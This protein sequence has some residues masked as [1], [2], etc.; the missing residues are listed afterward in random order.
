MQKYKIIIAYDGTDFHGWQIQPRDVTVSSCL[1]DTFK[2]VFGHSITLIGASRT[3]TG[4]HALGQV[5]QFHSELMITEGAMLDALNKALPKS[6]VIRRLEKVSDTF[7]PC[8][9]VMQ[10]TYYYH[11]FLKCPLPFVARYG[12]FYRFIDRVDFSKFEH[13]L[14]LYRGKHDFASFCKVEAEENKDTIR[15]I[16]SISMSK[17]PR[18]SI[19]RIEVKG[20][21]FL[22]Y[23]IR[24][25]IGYAL[26]VARRDSLSV[27]YL[28][29]VMDS[30]DPQQKLLKADGSGLCLRKVIYYDESNK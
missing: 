3:D 1:Q 8:C 24:R 10:K 20:Q 29:D 12:W 16:D 22:R 30:R 19:I 18:W 7:H 9:N 26:D 11:L 2:R 21:S 27:N 23:Q 17:F 4:V 15:T 5:A 25:M 13:C 28:Q 14:Q 6:I